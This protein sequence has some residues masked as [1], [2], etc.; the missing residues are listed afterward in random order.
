MGTIWS[1]PARVALAAVLATL[2]GGAFSAV[3]GATVTPP[4][5]V[6]RIWMP[7]PPAPGTPAAFNL[8]GS[9]LPHNLDLNRVGVIKVGRRT[10][11]NVLVFVPGTSAGAAY[12]VPFAKSLVERLGDWQVWSVERRENLLEDQSLLKRAKAGQ[13]TPQEVFHYYLGYLTEAGEPRPHMTLIPSERVSFA[14]EWGMNVAVEDLHTVIESA[15]GLGGKVALAG[16]SLGGSVVTAYATWDFAGV[17]GATGLSGLVYDDGG[18]SPTPVTKERAEE[19]LTKLSKGSPWLSF[20]GIG[21]PFLGLFSSLG[22]QST[23]QSP[24][25][26]SLAEDF[27]LLPSNLKPKNEKGELIAVTNEAEFG[28]GVNVGSSPPTLVA[29]QV[30]AGAGLE[31]TAREDG[32]VGW[33]GSGA[34]SPLRRYAEMLAGTATKQADGD[35]WYFPERLTIDTGAVAE[36]NSNPAQEVLGEHAIH[37]HELPSSLKILAISSE[38]DKVFGGSVLTSAE[39][40]AAQ[41]GIPSANLTLIDREGEYAHNDPAAAE[42]EGNIDGNAFY[43]GLVPFLEGIG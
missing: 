24:Q 28:Y 32:L 36:G 7:A 6:K 33:N 14:R 35:E 26:A 3:A 40:L 4:I 11:K 9:H 42:P 34:L 1:R 19:Q 10:A 31:E 23:V 16:H 15:K 41:S 13:A 18:S 17:P 30:H 5:K 27:S 21:S 8:P 29:A 43:A 22:A 25:E 20:G 2:L 38:L 12:I 39:I 37:G